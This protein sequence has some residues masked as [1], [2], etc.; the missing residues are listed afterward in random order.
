MKIQKVVICQRLENPIDFCLP[1]PSWRR[2][3]S[4]GSREAN[5]SR[6]RMM[7]TSDENVRCYCFLSNPKWTSS[8]QEGGN[9]EDGSRS[10][11]FCIFAHPSSS[12]RRVG[13]V[14]GNPW[15][16]TGSEEFGKHLRRTFEG[17]S[18]GVNMIGT[19]PELLAMLTLWHGSFPLPREKGSLKVVKF[20]LWSCHSFCLS[21]KHFC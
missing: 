4:Q 15:T 13:R 12:T 10:I 20:Y 7:G 3:T 5:S 18:V 14:G 16:T 6:E 8:R 11:L 21:W 9:T 17:G 19:V 2:R 1:F